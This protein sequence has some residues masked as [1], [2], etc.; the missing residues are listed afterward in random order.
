MFMGGYRYFPNKFNFNKHFKTTF[1]NILCTELIFFIKIKKS[2]FLEK[3]MR[4]SKQ[5]NL[6]WR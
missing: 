1:N 4:L 3:N 6:F 5:L 2:V